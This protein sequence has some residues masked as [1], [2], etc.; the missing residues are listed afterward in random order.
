M[1]K[2]IIEWIKTIILS[3]LIA[4]LITTFIKPTIVRQHSMS[5]T[6]DEYD[7]LIINR[8]L[9]KRSTPDYG[10]II[11]FRSDLK[12]DVG[13]SKL[14]IKRVI[15]LPSDELYFDEGNIYLNGKLLDEPYLHGIITDGKDVEGERLIVPD[16]KLFVM[17]DNRPNSMDSRDRVI[18]F[19]NEE[20]IVGKAFIRLFPFN[21]IGWL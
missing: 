7:F 17:G 4:L 10:D 16:G 14:L 21:R 15:A 9:Y 1:K 13:N 8:L 2:E 12:T 11:V 3:V 20:D 19:I 18:G 5:P 6:L